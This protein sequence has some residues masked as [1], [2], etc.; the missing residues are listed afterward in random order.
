MGGRR[1]RALVDSG[2][3]TTV[4][5]SRLVGEC[6]EKCRGLV[7][8]DGREVECEGT[9]EVE[10]TVQ[11]V[12]LSIRVIVL[13]KV[14]EGMD[15]VMGMDVISHLGGVTIGDGRVTFGKV[16]VYCSRVESKEL[17]C[18]AAVGDVGLEENIT[19]VRDAEGPE[20][21][22]SKTTAAEPKAKPCKIV[23]KDFA[24]EFDGTKWVVEWF[25]KGEP[26]ILKNTVGCYEH[27][28]REPVKGEFDREIERWIGEGVLVPWGKEVESGVLP[29]MPVVQPTKNKVRPVL[30][31][32]ELNTHV[33]CHTGD[34]ATDV[35]GETLRAWRQMSGA[36]TIVD[37][38]SAYLQVHVAKKLWKYQLVKYKGKTYCLTRMGFGLSSAPKSMTKILRTV[39]SKREGLEAATNSYIDDILVDETKVGVSEVVEHLQRYG[40]ATKRPEALEGGTAL[41]LRLERER[42]GE[43]VFKRGNTVPEVKESLNRREL[44]SVCGKL[45]GHYPVAGWLRVACSYVKRRAEGVAWDD[46]VGEETTQIIRDIV[47]RVSHDDPVRGKWYAPKSEKGVVWC[48]ASSIATG[49]MLEMGDAVVEDGAWLRKKEDYNHINVAELDAVLKGINLALKW[50]L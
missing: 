29:L 17:Q 23:D 37:L 47:G 33:M 7:A 46:K 34:D 43:L 31:F 21:M 15:I 32:R 2:C 30:D 19:K 28:M 49:V 26:P 24:A 14:I 35:C 44:F 4:C 27:A 1:V 40:L 6:T 45:V 20:K 18:I 13:V 42:T 12:Q 5:A 11:G 41:G 10:L 25:M 3:S 38:K 50:G 22:M 48:D 9:K 36:T 8:V 16:P 39:L